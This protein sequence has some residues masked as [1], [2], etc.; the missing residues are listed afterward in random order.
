V[1]SYELLVKTCLSTYNMQYVIDSISLLFV[2]NI[3]QQHELLE[4]SFISFTFLTIQ[5]LF[6]IC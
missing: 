3:I 2:R 5:Y 1:P 6:L 4:I